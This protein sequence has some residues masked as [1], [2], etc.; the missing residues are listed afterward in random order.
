MF[1]F[2]NLDL[3]VYFDIICG[4]VFYPP[5]EKLSLFTGP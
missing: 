5:G 4:D 3:N 2:L 1:F